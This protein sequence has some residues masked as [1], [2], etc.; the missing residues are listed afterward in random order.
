MGRGLSPLQRWILRRA[1]DQPDRSERGG[2]CDLAIARVIHEFYEVP[3][4]P[5]WYFPAGSTFCT[6]SQLFRDA[7]GMMAAKRVRPAISHAISRLERRGLV[8]V[9]QGAVARWSGITL[10]DAGR[11]HAGLSDNTA[12]SLP[13]HCPL[14]VDGG[15]QATRGENS[16]ELPDRPPVEVNQ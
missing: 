7:D 6:S 2:G 11:E 14:E 4:S 15:Y 16:T 12:V 1:A 9:M 8:N 3:L 13:S 10:T 5:T